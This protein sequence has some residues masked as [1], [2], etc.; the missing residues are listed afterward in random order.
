MGCGLWS[1]NLKITA[2]QS[3]IKH[4]KGAAWWGEKMVC[5]CVGGKWQHCP[6]SRYTLLMSHHHH[7]SP[8]ITTCPWEIIHVNKLRLSWKLW[9][10]S[11]ESSGRGYYHQ[12]EAVNFKII[13]SK[14]LV[15]NPCLRW[16]LSYF[17]TQ[18]IQQTLMM[19][20]AHYRWWM[21]R[22]IDNIEEQRH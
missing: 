13:F 16:W 10:Y 9:W 15:D 6:V 18:I 3:G 14:L 5:W 7:W 19:I 8:S 21:T 11:R 2:C 4:I 20:P 22:K 1:I 17:L 12:T